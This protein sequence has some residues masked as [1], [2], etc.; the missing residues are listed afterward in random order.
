M[1]LQD[2]QEINIPNIVK[3][4]NAKQKIALIMT[5]VDQLGKDPSMKKHIERIKKIRAAAAT[6]GIT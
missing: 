5:A 2:L 4:M 1:K 6:M 3:H